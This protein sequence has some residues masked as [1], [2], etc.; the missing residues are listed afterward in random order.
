LEETYNFIL[1]EYQNRG[2]DWKSIFLS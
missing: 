1:K 2:N